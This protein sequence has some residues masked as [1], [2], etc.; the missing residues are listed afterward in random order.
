MTTT[1]EAP[2]WHGTNRRCARCKRVAEVMAE[3]QGEPVA[4]D[5]TVL[6]PEEHARRDVV[7]THLW[8]GPERQAEYHYQT[9]GGWCPQHGAVTVDW[10]WA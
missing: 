6:C 9:S 7:L 10:E 1:H 8:A 4:Y 2:S 3:H 5:P